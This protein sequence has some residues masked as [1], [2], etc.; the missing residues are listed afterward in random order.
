MKK[1]IKINNES[2]E[3]SDDEYNTDDSEDENLNTDDELDIDINE[4]TDQELDNLE[5]DDLESIIEDESDTEEIDLINTS[6]IYDTDNISDNKH[7]KKI[8][9]LD[10][11]LI[12]EL[13]NK[14]KRTIPL[15]T[16]FEYSKIKALRVTQLSNNS[17]PFIKTELNDIEEIANEEIKQLKLPFI[18][19]RNFPSG[20]FEL[21]KLSELAIR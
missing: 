21:W 20:D 16:K 4:E 2:K 7:E 18:I 11:N 3:S 1:S 13:L 6:P 17:N 14:P 8:Q 19:K 10:N 5:N 12:K 9:Y 15:I